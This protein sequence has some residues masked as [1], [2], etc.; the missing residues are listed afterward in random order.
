MLRAL[1]AG[2]VACS[3]FP[4]ITLLRY[5]G[6]ENEPGALFTLKFAVFLVWPC[7]GA[8]ALL[9]LPLVRVKSPLR[10]WMFLGLGVLAALVAWGAALLTYDQLRPNAG[11]LLAGLLLKGIFLFAVFY[12]YLAVG[13]SL[14]LTA[15][16]DG[17]EIK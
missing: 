8:F 6:E 7:F 13:R 9:G 5:L 11:R 17:S 2:V 3:I 12:W 14:E 15:K 10:E 4:V 1:F 16:A